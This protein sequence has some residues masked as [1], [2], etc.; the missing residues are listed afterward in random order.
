MHV[1]DP[2]TGED[3]VEP[4]LATLNARLGLLAS[5]SAFVFALPAVAI[6]KLAGAPAVLWSCTPC[7]R[8]PSWPAPGSRSVARPGPP[9]GGVAPTARK[10]DADRDVVEHA[11]T[12]TRGDWRS[13]ATWPPSGPSPGPR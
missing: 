13:S 4:D 12:W 3:V 6:L 5:L 10:V 11:P 9:G 8:W 2:V 1:D 7:S